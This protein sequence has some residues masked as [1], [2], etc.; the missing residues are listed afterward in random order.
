ME[1]SLQKQVVSDLRA[2]FADVDR[3]PDGDLFDVRTDY[4]WSES[5]HGGSGPW[6]DVP[7]EAIAQ[8]PHALDQLTIEG[9]RF[10][11]PAYLLWVIQNPRSTHVTIDTTISALDLSEC[12][13]A[14][15]AS[16]ASR[17]SSLSPTQ[18]AAVAKFLTWASRDEVLDAKAA[19]SRALS[20]YWARSAE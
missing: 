15:L 17:F 2:A 6:W 8:E 16:R 1:T 4:L 14:M 19:A 3:R 9:F 5:L 10:F 7:A 13:E 12:S 20:K 18:R 11:L